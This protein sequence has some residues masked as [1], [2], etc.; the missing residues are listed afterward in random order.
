MTSLRID[1]RGEF[2][3]EIDRLTEAFFKDNEGLS[4]EEYVEKHGSEE[5]KKF[6]AETLA[7]IDEAE[8]RNQAL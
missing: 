4:A 7:R 2:G 1:S 5:Y 6:V 3:E 8:N